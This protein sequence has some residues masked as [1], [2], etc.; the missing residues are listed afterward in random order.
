MTGLLAAIWRCSRSNA[1]ERC[2]SDLDSILK[3]CLHL[4]GSFN[5][6]I[7]PR[8]LS[9]FFEPLRLVKRCSLD[10]PFARN[11]PTE[12][13]SVCMWSIRYP[14]QLPAE[15]SLSHNTHHT[16]VSVMSSSVATT[17]ASS[18]STPASSATPTTPPSSEAVPPSSPAIP[19]NANPFELQPERFHWTQLSQGLSQLLRDSFVTHNSASMGE[20][21]VL[22][23]LTKLVQE[24]EVAG[25]VRMIPRVLRCKSR[26]FI[27]E[28]TV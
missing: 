15:Y 18:S 21:T 6:H 23:A 9:A 5:S 20:C 4:R 28:T 19:P 8:L 11:W 12:H 14:Q 1:Q 22:T 13:L 24:I 16:S 27:K 17:I 25:E 10:C 7:L 26:W 3:R 2:C